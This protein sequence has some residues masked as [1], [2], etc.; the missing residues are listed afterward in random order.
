M[1]AEALIALGRAELVIPWVEQYKVQ[2]DGFPAAHRPIAKD[3]WREALGDHRRVGDWV[4]FF[5][6][7]LRDRRWPSVLD[8][9]AI[10]LAPGLVAAGTH[11]LIRTAHAVR[12]LDAGETPARRHELAQGLGFWAARYVCLPER[13][14]GG[15]T[16]RPSQAIRHVDRV[17]PDEQVLRGRIGDQ[18]R[19]LDQSDTFPV[20]ADLVAATA[21]DS[22]FLSDLTETFARVFL[23]NVEET[24]K[25]IGFIHAVTGP[26]AVRLIAPHVSEAASTALRRY[27]WQA[28][29]A[30]YAAM[31]RREPSDEECVLPAATADELAD[32]AAATLDPHAIKFTEACLREYAL[33]PKPVYLVAAADATERIRQAE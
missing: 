10:E 7:E 22:T 23:A 20:I 32:A 28:A 24:G 13:R 30:L 15:G 16:M 5:D 6:S 19:P 31:G 25:V 18:L 33:N 2:L 4:A 26:S 14:G 12:S 11:G 3:E 17:P 21:S 8:E 9:W 1:A 27:A 29:A